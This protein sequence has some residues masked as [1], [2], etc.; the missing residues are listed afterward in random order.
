M[1]WHY[2]NSC[3]LTHSCVVVGYEVF[4][5]DSLGNGHFEAGH[6]AYWFDARHRHLPEIRHL[7]H[8]GH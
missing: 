3:D 6:D 8:F 1:R 4:L 2:R 5:N 7:S